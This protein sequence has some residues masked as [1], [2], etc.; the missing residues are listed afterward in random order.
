MTLKKYC[1][2]NGKMYAMDLPITEEQFHEAHVK[3]QNGALIQDAFSFLNA[4]QREFIM[5]GTPPH[6]WDSM[7]APLP[8]NEELSRMVVFSKTK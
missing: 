1:Q 8:S 5:T 2:F 7:F 4:D 6:I 3:W